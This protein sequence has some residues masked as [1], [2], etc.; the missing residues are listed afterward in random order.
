MR[1]GSLSASLEEPA[2]QSR[3]WTIAGGSVSLAEPVVV[4]ILNLTPDSFSDGGD[5]PDLPSALR[6]A[7]RMIEE[8]AGI[9]DLGGESTR[10]GAAL[11]GESEEIDRV[12]PVLEGLTRHVRVPLSVD[13]RKAAVAR[14]ALTAGAAIVND[15]SGLAF[16]PGMASVVASGG[17]GVVLMHMRGTPE[18]MRER[19]HYGDVV[20]EVLKE[21]AE[22]VERARASGIPKESIVVDP[23]IGFAKSARQSLRVLGEIPRLESLGLPVLV[24][25]S[26]KSFLGEVLGVPPEERAVGT[27]AACLLAYLG[28]A[29]LFRVHDVAP[30]VQALAVARAVDAEIRA[31]SDP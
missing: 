15:V 2:P 20:G 5:L 1:A 21:L 18:D 30:T 25:P 31:R 24:G 3:S 11:V 23:G 8:G 17:A 7:E 9:L 13:T 28:G 16:D 6:R 22:A 4:G 29:R 19:A 12:L 14:A 26:R 10:P 27:A